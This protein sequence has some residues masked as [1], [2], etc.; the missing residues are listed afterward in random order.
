[1]GVWQQ[2]F[3][4]VFRSDNDADDDNDNDENFCFAFLFKV[5]C[6][7]RGRIQTKRCKKKKFFA[8]TILKSF[9]T[10]SILLFFFTFSP[11]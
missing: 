5:M 2:A 6:V 11:P 3:K 4:I 1:M 7:G 8:C 9:D 10:L